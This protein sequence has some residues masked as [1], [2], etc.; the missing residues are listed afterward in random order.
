M[1]QVSSKVTG[2]LRIEIDCTCPHCGN[3]FDA[4]E[5]AYDSQFHKLISKPRFFNDG[6]LWENIDVALNCSSCE[7]EIIIE[8]LEY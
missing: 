6:D 8:T 5:E 3:S 1:S 7:Q 2:T 4:F